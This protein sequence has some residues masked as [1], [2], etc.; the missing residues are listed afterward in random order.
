MVQVLQARENIEDF[1]LFCDTFLSNVVGRNTYNSKVGEARMSKIAT[2]SDEAFALVCVE[3]SIE[4]WKD[5]VS[6]QTK[7]NKSKWKP[8]K[9]TA[10][11]SEARKYGGWSLE[12]IR[13]FNE[14]SRTGVPELRFRSKAIENEYFLQV[15]GKRNKVKTPR[16]SKSPTIDECDVPYRDPMDDEDDDTSTVTDELENNEDTEPIVNARTCTN[17]RGV[18]TF[19]IH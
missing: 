18:W 15:N 17:I 5:E 2:V 13:R 4:R 12:G 11:P 10:N 9:Y 19:Y 14:L 3:N 6:N 16:R 8:S 7:T 1:T